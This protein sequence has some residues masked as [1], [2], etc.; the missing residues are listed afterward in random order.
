MNLK[1]NKNAEPMKIDCELD[2]E[3]TT[4]AHNGAFLQLYFATFGI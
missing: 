2:C 1:K 3:G 4:K